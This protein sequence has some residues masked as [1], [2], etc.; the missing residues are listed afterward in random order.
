[1]Y[2]DGDFTYFALDALGIRKCLNS[3]IIF[4]I[5]AFMEIYF[6]HYFIRKLHD[7]HFFPNQR[8]SEANASVMKT[9]IVKNS[10]YVIV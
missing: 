1:V 6:S 3:K 5:T 9:A 2:S 7:K 4:Y 10:P 8:I